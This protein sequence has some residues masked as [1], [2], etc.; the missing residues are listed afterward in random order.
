[1]LD[2]PYMLECVTLLSGEGWRITPTGW[3]VDYAPSTTAFLEDVGSHVPG[4]RG[5]LQ[6]LTLDATEARW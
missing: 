6:L 5:W 4:G 1:M 3:V 2:G